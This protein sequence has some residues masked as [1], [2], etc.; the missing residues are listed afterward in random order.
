MSGIAIHL[1]SDR[2]EEF[3]EL[4]GRVIPK[5][6]IS[7]VIRSVLNFLSRSSRQPTENSCL[8]LIHPEKNTLQ[9]ANQKTYAHVS[10]TTGGCLLVINHVHEW[11]ENGEFPPDVVNISLIE[12]PILDEFAVLLIAGHVPRDDKGKKLWDKQMVTDVET[13]MKV[14]VKGD[15]T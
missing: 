3:V 11:M 1:R 2:F 10:K 9:Q 12:S 4:K 6:P 8:H 15:G 14:T 5:E 13:H 7:D